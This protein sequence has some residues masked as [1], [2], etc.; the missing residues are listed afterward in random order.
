MLPWR[1]KVN[2][3]RVLVSEI[4][5]QQTQVERVID[6]YKEFLS[7]FPDFRGTCRCAHGPAARCLVGHGIQSAGAG[8]SVAGPAGISEHRG[9]LPREQEEL[10]RPSAGSGSTRPGR[11]RLLPS[12]C[13]SYSWTRTSGG[14]TFT[15][16]SKT[17]R[18]IHDDELLPLVEQ[19]MDREDPRKWYNALMDYGS[20]LK[21]R[22]GQ[23]EPQERCTTPG[24]V[25]SRTPTGRCAARS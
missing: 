7:A 14:S 3:Y 4:M 16:S 2:P 21:R 5:L 9:R 8:A 19:T 6:K 12:T 1:K 17:V 13:L 25:P 24:R 11:Y 23:S 10:A 22:P 20:M 15:N 18:D